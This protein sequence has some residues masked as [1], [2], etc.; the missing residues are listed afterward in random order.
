VVTMTTRR[1]EAESVS[2]RPEVAVDQRKQRQKEN[3][4]LLTEKS[5]GNFDL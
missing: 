5:G 1:D 4:R 3:E 2:D